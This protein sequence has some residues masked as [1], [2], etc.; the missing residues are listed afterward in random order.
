VLFNGDGTKPWLSVDHESVPIYPGSLCG[1]DVDV[2]HEEITGLKELKIS[3]IW[4]EIGLHDSYT[5]WEHFFSKEYMSGA[6]FN[7]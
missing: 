7:A 1:L 6:T 4:N 5:H 2:I 3:K